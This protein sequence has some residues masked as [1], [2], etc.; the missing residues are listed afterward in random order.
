M[1]VK[2]DK[3]G[4]RIHEPPYIQAEEDKFYR[5]ADPRLVAAGHP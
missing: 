5:Q 1:V 3:H 2:V 4:N